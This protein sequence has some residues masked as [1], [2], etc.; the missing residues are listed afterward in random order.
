MKATYTQVPLLLKQNTTRGNWKHVLTTNEASSHTYGHSACIYGELMVTIG[1]CT[2]EGKFSNSVHIFDPS[3]LTLIPHPSSLAPTDFVIQKLVNGKKWKL[4]PLLQ[5]D[6]FIV[7]KPMETQSS[8]TEAK[9]TDIT[10]VY[11][12]MI[13]VSPNQTHCIAHRTYQ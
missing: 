4:I 11:T 10:Q 13:S 6:I 7:A 3:E 12:Y 1:G 5:L 2:Q 9:A 8:S